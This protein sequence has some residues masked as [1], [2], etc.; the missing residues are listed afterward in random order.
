M[1]DE[2]TIRFNERFDEV[3]SLLRTV[4]D[5]QAENE[6]G[7]EELEAKV[8][9]RLYDTRPIW[10]QVLSR[11]TALDERLQRMEERQESMDRRVRWLYDEFK[12]LKANS[13]RCFQ[14]LL[15]F[16]TIGTTSRNA[17]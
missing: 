9:A 2:P 16:S 6:K 4:L 15:S 3:I 1:N 10:E 11:L 5:R 17:F 8:E 14:M 7:L 13:N 12:D